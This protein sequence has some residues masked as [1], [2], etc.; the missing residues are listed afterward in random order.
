L[1][2]VQIAVIEIPIDARLRRIRRVFEA[3]L[4]SLPGVKLGCECKSEEYEC[5]FFQEWL[6]VLW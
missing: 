4:E 6:S 5:C 2:G 1:A 3:L